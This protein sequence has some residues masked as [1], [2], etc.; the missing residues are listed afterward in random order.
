MFVYLID[1][2]Q[3]FVSAKDRNLIDPDGGDAAQIAMGQTIID[4]VLNGSR[5]AVPACLENFGN[6][7]PTDSSRPPGQ[8]DLERDRLLVFAFCPRDSFHQDSILGT[9]DAAAGIPKE[10]LE[11]P[12]RNVLVVARKQSIVHPA[13]FPTSRAN[14]S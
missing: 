14:R 3:V 8:E 1:Q 12:E 5:D 10:D 11:S 2:G 7:F 13:F 9:F 4:H 6:L